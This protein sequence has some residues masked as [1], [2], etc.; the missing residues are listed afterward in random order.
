MCPPAEVPAME[1]L[2]RSAPRV[3]ACKSNREHSLALCRRGGA[4]CASSWSHL[5][6]ASQS[7]SCMGHC[8][9]RTLDTRRRPRKRRPAF[10]P[11]K[12]RYS[13]LTSGSFG[14]AFAGTPHKG[15]RSRR[16][17]EAGRCQSVKNGGLWPAA[18]TAQADVWG[19]LGLGESFNSI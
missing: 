1:T 16:N 19:F 18:A 5:K 17:E 9:P 10:A 14:G 6:A 11:G 15:T 4:A 8:V 7:S 3:A 13:Q 12:R 2:E